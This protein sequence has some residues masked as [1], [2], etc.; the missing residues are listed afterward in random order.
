MSAPTTLAL[1]LALL[2]V[3]LASC[4]AAEG[5]FR[6]DARTTPDCA[7]DGPSLGRAPE[8]YSHVA[9]GACSGLAAP[10]SPDPLAR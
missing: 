9:G 10:L 8:P 5:A 6:H 3:P 4:A 1:A 7:M 2:A